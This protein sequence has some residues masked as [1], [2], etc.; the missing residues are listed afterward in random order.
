MKPNLKDYLKAVGKFI[1]FLFSSVASLIAFLGFFYLL[2]RYETFAVI[3]CLVVLVS[4]VGGFVVTTVYDLAKESAATRV[5]VST[6]TTNFGRLTFAEM[7]QH[8]NEIDSIDYEELSNLT[9]KEQI[10]VLDGLRKSPIKKFKVDWYTVYPYDYLEDIEWREEP[11]Y[12]KTYEQIMEDLRLDI[13][14]DL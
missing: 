6:V 10:I 5:Y 14:R 12:V 3:V 9:P 13:E 7:M 11:E 1:V 4:L 2:M 8:I